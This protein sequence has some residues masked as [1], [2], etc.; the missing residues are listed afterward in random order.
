MNSEPKPM[1]PERL[2]ELRHESSLMRV[3]MIPRSI[4]RVSQLI[5]EALADRDCYAR[6]HERMTSMVATVTAQL[7]DSRS[8]VCRLRARVRV[9]AADVE[10]AGVALGHVESWLRAD[11]WRVSSEGRREH[12]GTPTRW[13]RSG[14]PSGGPSWVRLFD[15]E[16]P[17]LLAAT[18]NA[19]A[20]VTKRP[21]LDILEEMS[22]CSIV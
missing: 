21:S 12:C 2:A 16:R 19:I 22:R 14:L 11:G 13:S 6:E 18:I 1:D 3:S 4:L 17:D 8:E 5:D 15:N 9:E 7:A 20:S 10:P